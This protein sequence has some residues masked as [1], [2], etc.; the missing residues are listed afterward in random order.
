MGKKRC[1]TCN[2]KIK[3]VMPLQ[4]KCKNYYCNMHKVASNHN[5]SFDF[6]KE[7]QNRLRE[8]NQKVVANKL[9]N[10]SSGL[11]Q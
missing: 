9:E 5:C 6:F 8:R 7:N 4:C 2:K 3:S 10:M 1:L 11:Y